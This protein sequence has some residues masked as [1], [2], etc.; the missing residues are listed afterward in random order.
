MDSTQTILLIAAV[1]IYIIVR[2]FTE[3]RVTW[4]TLLLLPAVS[5]Y[6]SYTELQDDFA[7][8]LPVLLIAAM[9]IGVLPG[10]LTGLFRGRHTR[11]R[12]DQASGVIYS[13]PEAASSLMWVGLL[14]LHIAVIALAYS[15]LGTLW[16]TGMLSAFASTLFLVSVSVQKWMVYQQYS[17]LQGQQMFT[18]LNRQNLM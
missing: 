12:L 4:T 7:H 2:Q 8:F 5:I 15:P 10:V 17:L 6:A 13:K 1:A 18:P 3:Q 11:V 16:L 9:V 14:V